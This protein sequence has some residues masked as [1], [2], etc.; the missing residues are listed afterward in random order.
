MLSKKEKDNNNI[1]RKYFYKWYKKVIIMRIKDETDKAKMK[2]E[3][4]KEKENDLM[5]I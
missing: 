5:T 3:K 1:K 2:E 4:L